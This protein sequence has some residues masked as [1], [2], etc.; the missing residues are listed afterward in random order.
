MWEVQNYSMSSTTFCFVYITNG[1]FVGS[2]VG[3]QLFVRWRVGAK[4][5]MKNGRVVWAYIDFLVR[6]PRRLNYMSLWILAVML[7]NV[8]PVVHITWRKCL[9]HPVLLPLFET[10]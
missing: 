10:T 3:V 5:Y 4:I 8:D 1:R 6:G 9:W 7:F 2:L